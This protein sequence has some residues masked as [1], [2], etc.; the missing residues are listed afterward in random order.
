MYKW[1]SRY[2]KTNEKREKNWVLVFL[3]KKFKR[4]KG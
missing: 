1:H 4:E 2:G 3:D